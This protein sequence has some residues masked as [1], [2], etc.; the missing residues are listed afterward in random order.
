MR[1]PTGQQFELRLGTARAVITQVA[2][3]IREFSIDGQHLTEPYGTDV[4]PPFGT[5]IVLV[6]WPTQDEHSFW[7]LTRG[8]C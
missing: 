8:A 4:R 6:P 5:G 1:N 2:A 3:S 7:S